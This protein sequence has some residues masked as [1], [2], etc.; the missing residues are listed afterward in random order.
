M[1]LQQQGARPP[2]DHDRALRA[3]LAQGYDCCSFRESER[4]SARPRALKARVQCFDSVT[5][6]TMTS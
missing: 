3:N 4:G 2:R 6:G 1:R 5:F